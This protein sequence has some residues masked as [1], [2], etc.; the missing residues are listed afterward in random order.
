MKPQSMFRPALTPA[1]AVTFLIMAGPASSAAPRF[2]IVPLIPSTL[3]LIADTAVI[4]ER[5]S[6]LDTIDDVAWFEAHASDLHIGVKGDPTKAIDI[7]NGALG[8]AL[9]AAGRSREMTAY[10]YTAAEHSGPGEDGMG[11]ACRSS[12]KRRVEVTECFNNG[13]WRK[14]R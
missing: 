4:R 14:V 9:I 1:L 12:G 7:L 10:L 5:L 8:N 3:H 6:Y 13:R 11:A 2:E